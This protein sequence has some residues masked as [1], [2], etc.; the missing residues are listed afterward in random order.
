MKKV[1]LASTALVAG[2]SEV[3]GSVLAK[4]MFTALARFFARAV[5]FVL[6][7]V[8]LGDASWPDAFR[9]AAEDFL[10]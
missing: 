6:L 2:A 7:S 8:Y 9:A 4:G 1:L 3:L 10:S 5:V